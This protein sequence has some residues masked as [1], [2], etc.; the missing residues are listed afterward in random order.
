M[1]CVNILEDKPSQQKKNTPEATWE[2]KHA[3]LSTGLSVK[4]IPNKMEKI[5][6]MGGK[7]VV[8]KCKFSR[9]ETGKTESPE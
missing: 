3:F 8:E 9:Q 1:F 7:M 5:R 4:E 2:Q 6:M